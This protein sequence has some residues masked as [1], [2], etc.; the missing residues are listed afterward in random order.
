IKLLTRTVSR[1]NMNRINETAAQLG[2]HLLTINVAIEKVR[3]AS[4]PPKQTIECYS[5]KQL[6]DEVFSL[7]AGRLAALRVDY[8]AISVGRESRIR[9]YPDYLR[10]AFLNLVLN[11]VDAFRDG[12]QRRDRKIL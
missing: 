10:N 5:I 4:R 12:R 6:W 7:M 11:T 8:R 2:D 1:E 9:V 3:S